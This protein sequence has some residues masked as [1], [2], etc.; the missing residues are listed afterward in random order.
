MKKLKILIA[1]AESQIR[2]QLKTML[3]S[4][5]HEAFPAAD[6]L[7]ALSIFSDQVPDLAVMDIRLPMADGI[8]AAQAM[9]RNRP[10]PILLLTASDGLV[11]IP[12]AAFLPIQGYLALPVEKNKLAAAID[13]AMVHFEETQALTREAAELRYDLESRKIVNQAKA[14]LIG[15]GKTE[16]EAYREI[17]LQ[18]RS[19]RV[20]MR[21]AA[22]EMLRKQAG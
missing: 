19:H 14:L 7:E 2:T 17:R 15:R 21:L 18:A 1:E 16:E 20:S 8:Q 4:L 10:I 13:E 11:P 12:N 22:G 9:C 5:G 6:G 3:C